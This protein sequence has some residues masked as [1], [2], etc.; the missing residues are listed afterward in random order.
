MATQA[1]ARFLGA[2]DLPATT[3]GID[4]QASALVSAAHQAGIPLS[5]LLGVYGMET[6]FGKNIS[7][8]TSGAMGAFQFLPSTAQG[9]GYPLTNTPT[10][11]QFQQQ[12]DAAATYLAQLFKQ[13]GNDWNAAVTAYSGGGYNADKAQQTAAQAGPSNL[14]LFDALIS[15]GI[16]QG[17]GDTSVTGGTPLT[18][19][20]QQAA[21]TLAG[22]GSLVD[23]F[24][25]SANWL[26][27]GEVIAGALLVILGLMALIGHGSS[28]GDQVKHVTRIVPVPV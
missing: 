2:L 26:R 4:Q 18:T 5:I 19:G 12:A 10:V 6:A 21:N 24:T 9:R 25:S 7:T 15:Q 20:V 13:H 22:A 14:G 27:L 3:V 16:K 1:L 11:A 17:T 8:S 28:V 23:F